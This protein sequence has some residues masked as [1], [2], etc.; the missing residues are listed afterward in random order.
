M[1]KQAFEVAELPVRSGRWYWRELTDNEF[2]G[3]FDSYNDAVSAAA[4]A[5][6]VSRD[7]AQQ[8]AA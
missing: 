8:A 6:A 4:Q 5:V 2:H 1:G 3:A 7:N